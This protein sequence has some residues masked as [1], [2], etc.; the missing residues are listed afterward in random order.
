MMQVLSIAKANDL[1]AQGVLR[2]WPWGV[3]IMV[4][5]ICVPPKPCPPAAICK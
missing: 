3:D 5:V 2:G 4:G 1:A